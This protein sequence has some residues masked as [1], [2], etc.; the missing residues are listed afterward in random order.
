MIN[1]RD[2]LFSRVNSTIRSASALILQNTPV[3]IQCDKQQNIPTLP[4]E[5]KMSAGIQLI[6]SVGSN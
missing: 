3:G 2:Q 6:P 1:C 5:Y 4:V